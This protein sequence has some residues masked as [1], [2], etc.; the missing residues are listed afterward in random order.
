MTQLQGFF[1]KNF[2]LSPDYCGASARMS[3]LAAFTMFQAIAAEHAE[4]IGV[5][6][7]AM[8]RRGAFW[9]TLHS[10]V[11][12][13]RWPALAQEVTAATWP[14]HCEG[15]S[16]RCFRSYSLR[17]GDQL[18]ALG[19]TQ[20]AVLGEKGRLIPFPE[21]MNRKLVSAIADLY[22]CPTANNRKNLEREGITEAPARF[23]DDLLPEELVQRHTVRSTDI[24]MGRH[25]NNVAYVRLLLD[26]FPASVLAGGE[27]ASMEIHYAAPCF[28][29]E[30]LSVFCRREGSICRMA[31]RKPDGKTAVLAAVRFHEK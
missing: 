22:F 14:E 29:G 17:Q 30:E 2:T 7:A 12:F 27:I 31:V 19:R 3:P 18:L 15:R 21:E 13:F 23:R 8:A 11:D 16:L 4:R 6:G 1:E 26:C 28:E 10:R 5:G 24:D 20:W 25:M 9:L